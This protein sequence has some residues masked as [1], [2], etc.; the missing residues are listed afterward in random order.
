VQL[1][2]WALAAWAFIGTFFLFARVLPLMLLLWA[3]VLPFFQPPSLEALAS[4]S[5]RNFEAVPWMLVQ[6]GVVNSVLAMLLVPT[7]T[8]LI[9]VAFSWTML[10]TKTPLR[11][12][13]DA[14]AFVPHAVPSIIFGI[15]VLVVVLF[16][17][18]NQLPLYGSLASLIIAYVLV[19]LSFGTRMTN[20][21]LIQIHKELVEAAEMAGAG[22]WKV[23]L[24]ILVPL[25]APAL[26]GGWLWIALMS[27]RE[28]AL[29]T[30]LFSP[31]NLTLSVVV[32][33]FWQGG[34]LGQ[35]A[36]VSLVMILFFLPITLLYWRIGNRRTDLA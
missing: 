33:N 2:K 28:L 10:Y 6:R 30:I 3:A 15:A 20:S 18:G 27:L 13:F 4:V 17:I 34:Q 36:A 5:F 21:A 32:W 16:V 26:V 11:Q 8:L 23:K 14:I 25:I 9:S 12:Y 29:P 19:R 35:A 7:I 1:G 24:R 31:S 22:P